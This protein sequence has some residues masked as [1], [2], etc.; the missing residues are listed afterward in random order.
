[1]SNPGLSRDTLQEALNLLQQY[2]TCHKAA[3]ATGIPPMTLANRVAR[4]Q[5][6]GMV[7]GGEVQAVDLQGRLRLLETKLAAAEKV[8]I[9]VDTVKREIFKLTTD[10]EDPPD[11]VI[12]PKKSK[13]IAGVATLFLS[14]LHWGEVVF[15]N[16]VNG[17]NEY[18]LEIAEKRLYSTV[19]HAVDLVKNHIT[20]NGY[21]GII[22]F[23]GGDLVSGNIHE[24]LKET[25]EQPIMPV[26]MHLAERLTQCLRTLRDEFKRVH[27]AC[28]YGNHGRNTRKPTAKQS[29]FESFDWLIY[30]LLRWKLG[31]DGFTWNIPD[32]S[33]AFQEVYGHK[34]L[35]THGDQ[36][37][38]G[39][40]VIG[41]LG[42]VTRGDHKK[43]SRN[44]QIGLDY[45]TMCLGHWHQ[46]V[47]MQRLIINGSLKGYDEYAYKSNFPFEEPRQALW[48][49][50]PELGL[51][52][53]MP[54][55]AERKK[56]KTSQE[57]VRAA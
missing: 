21:P 13:A 23:L 36:F 51:T 8:K 40:S 28:V 3:K 18:N 31:D 41:A 15:P 39:D 52:F 20:N 1:M 50:H 37:R 34:Y 45:D 2:G 32:G 25:N 19:E 47:Q 12:K 38:G 43:R 17:V 27:L 7:A 35:L 16:Q 56:H 24:E 10:F 46:L 5:A 33:D 54:V 26:V 6:S 49:T 55:Y 9:D 57:W 11:W 22:V 14:D 44:G 42:P 30:Q 53:S 4:A 48:M 29:A